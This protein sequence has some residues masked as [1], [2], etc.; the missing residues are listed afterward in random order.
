MD[1][2]AKRATVHWQ[3]A[4]LLSGNATNEKR[5]GNL[6]TSFATISRHDLMSLSAPIFGSFGGVN[7]SVPVDTMHRAVRG[8]NEDFGQPIGVRISDGGHGQ[9]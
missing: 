2:E 3:V 5:I 4:D 8:L 6:L 1:Y 9:R 7:S